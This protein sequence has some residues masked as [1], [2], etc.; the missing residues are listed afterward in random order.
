MS[1]RTRGV[2]SSVGTKLLVGATGL[3][4]VLY[5]IIHIA[6]NLMVFGGADLFNSYAGALSGNPVIIV[7]EVVLLVTFLVHAFKTIRLVTANRA[8]RPVAYQMKRPAGGPSRKSAAST[9]MILSGLWLLAF[10]VIHVRTFKFGAH[11]KTANGLTDLY[12]LEMETF[13]DPLTVAFYVLSMLV[14]GSHVFHGA[15][16]A[17]QSLGFDHPRWTPRIL[18]IGR[19]LAAG[20]AGGFIVIALWAHLTGGA[21]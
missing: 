2:D 21:R 4:L 11:H 8:A 12:R 15:S 7:I 17:F 9:S 10:V 13:R 6:G 18:V 3:F 14:V 5:L 19:L 1:S 16:S 20:I